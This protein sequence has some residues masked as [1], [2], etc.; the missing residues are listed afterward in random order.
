MPFWKGRALEKIQ[1]QSERPEFKLS[2]K[3]VDQKDKV[4]EKIPDAP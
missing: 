2:K 4:K 3:A 1:K